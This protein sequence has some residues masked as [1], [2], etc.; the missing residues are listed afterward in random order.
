MHSFTARFL[1]LATSLALSIPLS[2]QTSYE[3]FCST[4][5]HIAKKKAVKYEP[6]I[7]GVRPEGISLHATNTLGSAATLGLG[8]AFFGGMAYTCFTRGDSIAMKIGGGGFFGSFG[9]LCTY[10]AIDCLRNLGS[11]Y[12][13]LRLYFGPQGIFA[14]TIFDTEKKPVVSWKDLKKFTQINHYENGRHA[15]T[16]LVF[17]DGQEN[18]L[19][20]LNIDNDL[21]ITIA[22]LIEVIEYFHA[23]YA[24]GIHE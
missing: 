23:K 10:L 13:I 3:R 2:A 12:P 19:W 4:L 15:R 20:S 7:P 21:P 22:E 17:Q 16:E 1:Y 9:I 5:P 11:M 6:L 24:Q 18:T 8:G 14:K